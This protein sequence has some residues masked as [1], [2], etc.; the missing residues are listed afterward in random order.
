MLI[1]RAWILGPRPS[2]VREER[3]KKCPEVLFLGGEVEISNENRELRFSQPFLADISDT[4]FPNAVDSDSLAF[5]DSSIAFLHCDLG[6][7]VGVHNVVG[8]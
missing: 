8:S 7:F 3:F 4:T 2:F 5:E 6:R 1:Y